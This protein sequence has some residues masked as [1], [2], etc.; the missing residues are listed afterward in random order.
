MKQPPE[1]REKQVRWWRMLDKRG[2]KLTYMPRK[3]GEIFRTVYLEIPLYDG[4]I[5]KIVEA[6]DKSLFHGDWPAEWLYH[7]ILSMMQREFGFGRKPP[8]TEKE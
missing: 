7:N 6:A 5:E 3:R 1:R 2:V 4:L 8:T